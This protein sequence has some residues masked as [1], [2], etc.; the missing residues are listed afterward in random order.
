MLSDETI[1]KR[2]DRVKDTDFTSMKMTEASI[3]LKNRHK[4]KFACDMNADEVNKRKA[5]YIFILIF[6]EC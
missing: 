4:R 5:V 1:I 3:L 6:D 2:S